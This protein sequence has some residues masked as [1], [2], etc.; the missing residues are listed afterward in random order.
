MIILPDDDDDLLKQCEVS[1][2]RSSGKGGQHVN[3]TDSAVRV[4]HL[5]SGIT[6]T[7]QETRSQHTNKFR[8]LGKIRELVKK[9]NHKPKKRKPTKKTKASKERNLKK[10][11]IR[12]DVKKSRK[13]PDY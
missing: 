4:K 11:K 8:C 3:T 2:F 5:P 6:V 13:K 9:R 10:K 12:S 7:C 1:S